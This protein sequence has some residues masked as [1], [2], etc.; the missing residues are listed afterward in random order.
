MPILTPY[1]AT[2]A[3][4][5]IDSG[6][7]RAELEYRIVDGAISGQNRVVATNLSLGERVEAPNALDLP[8]DL[9]VAVL[10]D[11]SGRLAVEVPVSGRLGDP[12]FDYAT[13]IREAIATVVRRVASAPFRA[14]ARLGGDGD[15]SDD[16]L[17]RIA[18]EPGSDR[19]RPVQQERL[20]R[21]ARALGDRPALSLRIDGAYDPRRDA[22]ALRESAARRALARAMGIEAPADEAPGPVALEQ[23]AVR[24]AIGRLLRERGLDAAAVD[25]EADAAWRRLV[26]AQPLPDAALQRLA[27]AR[28]RRVHAYLAQTQGLAADHL[29]IGRLVAV[30]APDGRIP[31]PLA[32][33]SG[34][35]G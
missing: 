33:A 17:D 6:R 13:L 21:L 12:R 18:F 14:L 28:A 30:D 35:P 31:V 1:L 19:L 20:S 15:A 34:A 24:A 25:A 27:A 11:R 9:A 16:P 29:G 7:L 32:L 3:G 10:T 26:D 22:A 8:L 2:F 23:D 4:R 5:T